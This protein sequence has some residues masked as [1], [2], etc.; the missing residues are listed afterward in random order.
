MK[1]SILLAN[2][3]CVYFNTTVEKLSKRDRRREVALPRQMIMT[4]IKNHTTYADA[5]SVFKLD[6]STAIHAEKVVS[7]LIDTNKNFVKEWND[8]C[9]HANHFF[10][11]VEYKG[12]KISFN[13]GKRGVPSIEI[14]K[15]IKS[16]ASIDLAKAY[17]DGVHDGLE[18]KEL[19]TLNV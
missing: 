18:M 5:S 9:I 13:L 1:N 4:Y 11:S 15:K 12:V 10:E 7:N 14:D 19:I 3:L 16:F 17:I 2:H 8:F 6:H